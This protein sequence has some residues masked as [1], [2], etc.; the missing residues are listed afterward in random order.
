MDLL[1]FRYIGRCL[2]LCGLLILLPL[3]AVT[4]PVAGQET[5]RR[6]SHKQKMAV[7]DSLRRQ[8]RRAADEGRMLQWSDSLLKSRL[9]S[10]AIDSKRY[11][12]LRRRLYKYDRTLHRGDSLL[13]ERYGKI[14]YDTLYIVRPEGRWTIKLRGN[15]SGAK[16]ESEGMRHGSPYNSKVKSDYRGTMSFAVTYRGVTLG[17]AL[18]PAKLAGKSKDNELN[19]NSYSNRFGFDVVYL[20]SKT[21]HG[22]VLTDGVRADV[23]KGMVSQKALNFNA[24]YAFN[25]RRFSMPAAFS[26][27]YLQR[28]SAGS[29]MAGM[30]FDGQ[31]NDIDANSKA[32]ISGIK[33]KIVEL[34]L[35]LGY[36]YN[37]V[38][39]S[40][41]L[42]HLSVLPT[43][44]VLIKSHITAGD[45]RVDMG[46]HF[47]S[48]II[49]GRG[50]AVYSWK[51]KFTGLTMVYN[52]S[53]VG[54]RS[55]LMLTRDKW[56]IRLFYG[57]R[58]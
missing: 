11:A 8:L 52:N 46:Y 44:D 21:Y 36:G 29:I 45:E 14:S 25:W 18:N 20:S 57:F 28:R 4:M 30:S 55:N 58:F 7:A 39:G 27:S 33:L 1:A 22:R 17:L 23:S 35:G 53:T 2:L 10:G 5:A 49:T 48:V 50:A 54:K 43:F 41:W 19:L 31:I 51:R 24:Y 32:G 12:K 9:K 37:L 6:M 13:A 3:F 16:I 34:G 26:Q 56:R 42:F 47:P 40:R 15:L 38:A